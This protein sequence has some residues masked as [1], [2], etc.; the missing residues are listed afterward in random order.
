MGVNGAAFSTELDKTNV[1]NKPYLFEH[2]FT[3]NPSETGLILRFQLEAKNERGTTRS[4]QYLSVLLARPPNKPSSL[5][6]VIA[7]AKD[8]L[9][10]EMP[11]VSD[12]GGS[13]II[14]VE[15][16]MDDGL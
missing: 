3:F 6:Q 9:E 14:S 13:T 10:I 16:V 8:R 4:Q 5:V 1:E 12:D 7:T 11:Q 2:T 15:L